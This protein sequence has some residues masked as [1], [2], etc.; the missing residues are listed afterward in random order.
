[1]LTAMGEV[2]DRIEGLDAGADD[3]VV[4]PFEVDELLARIRA[5]LRRLDLPALVVGPLRIDWRRRIALVDDV[6]LDLTARE[7]SLLAHLAAAPDRPFARAELLAAVWH[8]R[9]DPGTNV[10]EVYVN[11]VR[12]KLGRASWMLETVRGSG[13]QLRGDRS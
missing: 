13:Y 1:M 6:P 12:N 4:K 2:G 3:Y 5:Q 7:F 8:M 10:V 11:R 9:F